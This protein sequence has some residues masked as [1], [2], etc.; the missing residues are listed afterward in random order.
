M[1]RSVLAAVLFTSA[2]IATPSFAESGVDANIHPGDDFF[3]YANGAWL[4]GA[5]IP[6]GS[7]RWNA[8]NEISDLSRR[9]ADLL[10]AGAADAPAGTLARKVAD[11]HAAYLNEAAI[12]AAGLDPLRPFF[13]RIDAVR[14]KA[15]LTRLLGSELRADVDPLNWGVYNSAG[16]LGLAVESGNQGEGKYVAFL[17]QGGL[18]LGDREKY[19]DPSSDMQLLRTRYLERIARVLELLGLDRAPARAQAV[20]QLET[21]IARTH[22]TSEASS[23]ERNAGNLWTR[24]DFA[25]RAPDL[26]WQAFFSVTGLSPQ[27]DLVVWQP[28]AIEGVAKLVATY[29]LESWQD[30]L[31]F[32][33]V[34][35]HADCLP[36]AFATAASVALPPPRVQRAME[37]TR[38]ALSGVLGRLYA[39]QYFPARQK[40][41]VQTIVN[42]VI[43][44]FRKRIDAASWLSAASRTQ[45]QG[46]LAALY[47]GVAYPETWPDYSTLLIDPR[48]ASGNQRRLDDWNYAYAL[49]RAGRPDPHTDWWITPH[50]ASAVLLFQQNAYNFSA[51]LLQ[52]PKFDPDASDAMNYGAIGAIAGHEVSH[53]VDT[54][55]ADYEANGRKARWWTAADLT[56]YETAVEPLVRQFSLYRP[57]PDL[58]VDGKLTLVENVADLAGLC[59]AFDAYRQTLGSRIDD[60]AFVRQQD[61]QFFIGFARAWRAKYRDEALR[62]LL[63]TDGHAP[64][65]YRVATVR[66][67]DAWYEAFDVRPGHQL[68]LDPKARVR[69]W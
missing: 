27:Q 65:S 66:N 3:A 21:A 17:L 29:P 18:G 47:F 44:A 4:K 10:I 48:D 26:D 22:A 42:N 9:Q 6:A 16:L 34:E 8:R 28:G 7:E 69:I 35:R 19:L 32:H 11:F 37:V 54:L 49:G 23:D 2:I 40:T 30:Y 57:F 41:R 20:M 56:Q 1:P 45:A 64:E 13:E 67:L 62:K 68:Y 46:K 36:R 38:Q 60:K 63:T 59:A 24:A 15:A 43:A 5:E 31:R 52:P 61:R 55:G 25:R 39:G 51:A 58:A 53:F 33:F 12:E 50:S 14:D